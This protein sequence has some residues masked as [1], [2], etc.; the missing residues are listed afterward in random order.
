MTS[1]RMRRFRIRRVIREK[2]SV[3]ETRM[4]TTNREALT[5]ISL[6]G[7]RMFSFVIPARPGHGIESQFKDRSLNRIR[8]T[9]RFQGAR[10]EL[11]D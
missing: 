8:E 1:L 9:G 11:A 10:D 5:R 2:A 4:R 6:K 7:A 3:L